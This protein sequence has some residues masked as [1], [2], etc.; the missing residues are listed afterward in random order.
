MVVSGFVEFEDERERERERQEEEADALVGGF[1]R[2][3][4]VAPFQFFLTFFQNI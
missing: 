3:N 4:N 2:F 1:K